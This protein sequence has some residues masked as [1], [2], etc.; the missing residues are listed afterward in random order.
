[1]G[2]IYKSN[3]QTIIDGFLL[4]VGIYDEEHISDAVKSTI[5]T[6]CAKQRLMPLERRQIPP[7]FEIIDTEASPESVNDKLDMLTNTYAG[8]TKRELIDL[9]KQRGLEVPKKPN[10]ADL[11]ALLV[12]NDKNEILN[13]DNRFTFK[14]DEEFTDLAVQD[15]LQYLNEIFNLPDDIEENSNDEVEY[16]NALEEQIIIYGNLSLEEKVLSKIK[17]ILHYI[18]GGDGQ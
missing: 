2:L 8:K 5:E 11:V 12:D 6:Y 15:Q 9:C 1:M 3:I 7:Y 16:M 4:G 17:D 10:N 14:S 13:K 18:N